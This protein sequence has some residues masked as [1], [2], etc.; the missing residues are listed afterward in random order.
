MK[1]SVG[2]LVILNSDKTIYITKYDESTEKYRGYD[3]E[4]DDSSEEISF[5]EQEVLMK[6]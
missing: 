1:Y 5:S 3:I 2:T 4:K 6:I